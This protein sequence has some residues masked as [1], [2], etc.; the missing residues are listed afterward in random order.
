MDFTVM[1]SSLKVRSI[2]GFYILFFLKLALEKLYQDKTKIQ[3]FWSCHAFPEWQGIVRHVTSTTFD[4]PGT[5][6]LK[7]K[8]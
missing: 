2:R 8:E 1:L 3:T 5:N 4:L 6:A 7:I